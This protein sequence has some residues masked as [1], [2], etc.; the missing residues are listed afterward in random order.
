MGDMQEGRRAVS[1]DAPRY[2]VGPE[3]TEVGGETT[4]VP[5]SESVDQR[6]GVAL[7]AFSVWASGPGSMCGWLATR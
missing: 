3:G 7:T 4:P 1:A 5:G 6:A 2:D